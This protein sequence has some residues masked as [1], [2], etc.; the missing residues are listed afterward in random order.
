MRVCS[1]QLGLLA[2][3]MGLLPAAPNSNGSCSQ[4]DQSY[5]EFCWEKNQTLLDHAGIGPD[6][7]GSGCNRT[8]SYVGSCWGQDPTLSGPD[9]KQLYPGIHW[10]GQFLI[11]AI[12]GAI[13]SSPV[14]GSICCLSLGG[15]SRNC[16][17]HLAML[18]TPSLG[19]GQI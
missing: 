15:L 5:F 6:N 18:P 8:Q 11:S 13:T 2:S 1:M 10:I 17:K 9:P 19:R 7:N 14:C 3:W 12:A 16:V 4:P